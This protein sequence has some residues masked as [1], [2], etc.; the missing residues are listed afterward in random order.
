VLHDGVEVAFAP[1]TQPLGADR[2]CSL[3][4]HGISPVMRWRLPPRR[5]LH[6]L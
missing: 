6:A 3:F 5:R 4:I 1:R 2:F